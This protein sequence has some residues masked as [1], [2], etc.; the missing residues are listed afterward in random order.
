MSAISLVSRSSLHGATLS[1][2]SLD[3]HGHVQLKRPKR[4]FSLSG[5]SVTSF[6]DRQPA[7]GQA[8]ETRSEENQPSVNDHED[9]DQDKAEQRNEQQGSSSATVSED[10][11]EQWAESRQPQNN[12]VYV[13]MS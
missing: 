12:Q 8:Q 7:D 9:K 6:T 2:L 1:T 13:R 5:E 4:K 10:A 11:N 3:D